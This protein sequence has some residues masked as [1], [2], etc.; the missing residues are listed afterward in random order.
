MAFEKQPIAPEDAQLFAQLPPEDENMGFGAIG[1]VRAELNWYDFHHMWVPEAKHLDTPAFR[2]ELKD[3]LRALRHGALQSEPQ[4]SEFC[5]TAQ[6]LH[7]GAAAMKIRSEGY[8]YFVRCRSD[9]PGADITIY[10]YDNSL[11]LPHL[12]GK[13]ALPEKCYAVEDGQLFF[14]QQAHPHKLMVDVGG[15]AQ[16]NRALC[17]ELN[18]ALGVTK[19]QAAAMLMGAEYGFDQPCAWPWNYLENGEVRDFS[20]KNNDRGAR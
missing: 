17:D 13:H 11:L 9:F 20:R 10:A 5:Q 16:E 12:A 4:L 1:H 19:A 14:V 3:L 7:D 6:R 8:T 18:A 15:T 2:R